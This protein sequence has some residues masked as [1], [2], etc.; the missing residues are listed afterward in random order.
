MKRQARLDALARERQ[1]EVNELE[2]WMAPTGVSHAAHPARL[3]DSRPDVSRRAGLRVWLGAAGR[4]LRVLCGVLALAG[5]ALFAIVALVGI[6]GTLAMLWAF[7]Q[8]TGDT[9]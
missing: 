1:I 6:A 8:I 9:P 2:R 7:D 5:A 4:Y 3:A